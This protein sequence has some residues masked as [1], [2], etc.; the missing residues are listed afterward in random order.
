MQEYTVQELKTVEQWLRERQ[1]DLSKPHKEP[2]F[3]ASNM[4]EYFYDV[5][6]I[7]IGWMGA[8]MEV[9]DK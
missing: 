4:F 9:M 2:L 1:R 7:Q 6:R 3:G 8:K 5:I